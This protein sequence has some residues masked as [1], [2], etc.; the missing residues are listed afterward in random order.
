[1]GEHD[2]KDHKS[3]KIQS[4]IILLSCLILSVITAY[5][6]YSFPVF[7][8]VKGEAS[9]S[10]FSISENSPYIATLLFYWQSYF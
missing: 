8:T 10:H 7:Y 2:E 6:N 5:I 1:M 3:E 4:L 9:L